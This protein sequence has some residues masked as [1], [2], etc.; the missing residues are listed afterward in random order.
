MAPAHQVVSAER[1]AKVNA[2]RQTWIRQLVDMSRRNN[3]LYF[4]DLKAGTLDL[5]SADA[6]T[7]RSLL[8]SGASGAAAVRVADLVDDS[9]KTQATAALAEIANRAR[10]NFEERGL[11]TLFLAMGLATWTAQD[12]GKDSSSPVLL[13]PLQASQSG[14]RSGPWSLR[15]SGDVKFNDVLIHA[16]RQEHGVTLD[17][18]SLLPEV[19]GDDEGEAFDLQ[20]VFDAL[21]SRAAKVPGFD[22]APRWVIGNFAFQ[23]MAIVNDLNELVGAL[24]AHDTVAAI[25]GD[26][27]ATQSARGDRVSVDP[28]QF[29]LQS[30]DEEFLI[31]DADSSQ[32]Q[33][34]AATLRGQNG[35]ISGP[36]GTGK[37]QTISNLIAEL[38][39]RGKTVLFV[40]EKRAALDVVL[41]RLRDA[42]LAHLCLDCH[43]AELSRRQI[44]QQFQ[45][46]LARVREAPVPDDGSV[47]KKLVERRNRLNA[48]LRTLHTPR[49]P[50]GATL[51]K[52]YGRLLALPEGAACRSRLSKKAM[53][54]FDEATLDA[55]YEQMRE[56][57]TLA[58]LFTGDSTAPWSGASLTNQDE[59]RR[60][61]ERARRLA[62]ERWSRW[63]DACAALLAECSASAPQ[64]VADARFILATLASIHQ[65]L[66][67]ADEGIFRRELPKLVA[68]LAPARSLLAGAFA[69]LFNGDFR[70]ALRT[71]R[72]DCE[73]KVSAR[74]ALELVD[75]AQ[76]QL[77][78]WREMT[79]STSSYPA[80][81]QHLT[82][83]A[84]AWADVLE[85]LAPLGATFPR[86]PLEQL[87]VDEIGPW[88]GRLGADSTTPSQ[89]VKLHGIVTAFKAQGLEPLINEIAANR[90]DSALWPDMLRSA[91][92]SSCLD[93]VQ[94]QDP[95]VSSFMGRRHDQIAA[96]FRELDLKRLGVA[97]QRVQ[98]AH[99]VKA[100]EIRNKFPAQNT[101]VTREAE[102]KSRHLPLRRLFAEAPDVLLALRPC[103]MAS[104]LSVSQLIPG[105]KPLFDVVIFD[106][107]SQVLPEDAI[108]S[109]LRG[110]QAVIAGDKKQ[111][112]PTT[113]F[114]AGDP[115]GEDT[116]DESGT[117]GFQ[118]ILDVMSSFLEPAWSLD[119][120]YRSRDEALI[121]YSNHRIYGGR[122]VTF[123]GPGGTGAV[124][125]ELV[126]HVP[127]VGAQEAS[128]SAEVLTVV[129]LVRQHAQ[130]RPHE[131]LGVITM[132][133]E[134]ARRI[135][136]ALDRA[137]QQDGE[138]EPLFAPEQP[139]RFFVKN[140]E[141][142]Q[143]DERDAIILST[144]YGKND[145]GQ[146]L[147]RFGPL[148]QEGG[149]RR[150]NVAI[151]RARQRMTVVSSFSH[152]DIQPDY[153]KVGVQ[154]L[155]GF[156][157]Y[158]AS[159]GQRFERGTVSDV[160]LNE[161]E[162]SVFDEL[163]RHG[164]KLVGQVGSS[165]YRIDMVAMHP[166]Q[167]GRFVLAIE[168]DGASY[169][170]A[171]TA[172]DRDR[173]RQQQL[174]ALGW[175][176]L[177]IWSTDW[178]LRR[179]EEVQR[180]LQA[181]QE[182][183][184]L[185]DT[186]RASGVTPA[187]SRAPV[188]VSAPVAR[189]RGP[190]PPV[191]PG[192][193]IGDYSPSELQ[194]MVRWVLS[195]GKLITDDE[196][197]LEVTRE[198]GFARRGNRIMAA[199]AAAIHAVQRS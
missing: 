24:A 77:K 40:A 48:H 188:V 86:R 133:I 50:G 26:Q 56:M 182:A 195:D 162:Q 153:P 172:R 3:L 190:R 143:G 14:G 22:I 80:K 132:G 61:L 39:A 88:L 141:R 175:R 150:L 135:E 178:F 164:L 23:K 92:L 53:A 90:P 42:D 106:E 142:V 100:L 15:R 157:E 67:K 36:P 101:L 2:A 130:E 34:I 94:L 123:P 78:A 41:N 167:Q 103:W 85:D 105:D 83:A 70:A 69:T 62:N 116:D 114:A 58:G 16:L 97:V 38:V 43:G 158:A 74:Q 4:R 20:P 33:A 109:L 107:A 197:V 73:G 59:V 118:S 55:A 96:E 79:A 155:R 37:S 139:E 65:T 152:H 6:N 44:A 29:D 8:Q 35:V 136:M 1:L 168:C 110:K 140:L 194:N 128:V 51:F 99:A 28:R 47:H 76:D 148:L 12:G 180:T 31:R 161:F 19:L 112:P 64:T 25:A 10:S 151:T 52:L 13:V 149:E 84:A 156:L 184:R 11:D 46:S 196:L 108:T 191:R 189:A 129:N 170:S 181:F 113:F 160:P 30:P 122:L 173:L 45:E 21:R 119:W 104:P 60:A 199:M 147:Y 63:E 91:W 125:H 115:G 177:R 166:E 154:V 124:H 27:G 174:E 117:A 138:L 5:S 49:P 171:P 66:G 137:R 32:Q 192:L 126:P 57:A 159:G 102:K 120:H 186:E 17:A 176:F 127:G 169:H 71:V 68:A 81:L 72:E 163:T 183:V 193:N 89:V 165:R 145:A 121:A 7:M 9:R 98:R 146:L 131:S 144:G 95:D 198:L 75:Q 54:T 82:A 134:H 185:S 111:L 18:E 179:E 87:R 187:V 93:E